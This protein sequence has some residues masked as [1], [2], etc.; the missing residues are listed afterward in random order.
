MELL[1][2][3]FMETRSRTRATLM[4]D[5]VLHVYCVHHINELCQLLT[6]VLTFVVNWDQQNICEFPNPFAV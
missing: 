5:S 2:G 1:C 3:I 6:V 4:I